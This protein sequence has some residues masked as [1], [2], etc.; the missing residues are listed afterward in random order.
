[1]LRQQ[2][3]TNYLSIIYRLVY[4]MSENCLKNAYYNFQDLMK[5][6]SFVQKSK[7]NNIYIY[8]QNI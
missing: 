8:T 2:Q 5:T 1:M 6:S 7:I 4:K 3:K